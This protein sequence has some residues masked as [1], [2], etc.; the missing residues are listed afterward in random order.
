MKLMTTSVK[1]SK[2]YGHTAPSYVSIPMFLLSPSYPLHPF[3]RPLMSTFRRVHK[4][5]WTM[6]LGVRARALLCY[7]T[8]PENRC[9][10]VCVCVCVCMCV[11]VC[12]CVYVRECVGVSPVHVCVWCTCECVCVVHVSM[13]VWCM[14]VWCMCVWCGVCVW[15]MC[16]W[17]MCECVGASPVHAHLCIVFGH[18]T[19][20]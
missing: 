16:E 5:R 3:L 8:M 4:E 15:C 10:C 7:W 9:V 14:C 20:T 1:N 11:C 19:C 17:R 13:C 2:V 6:D 18:M 12:V